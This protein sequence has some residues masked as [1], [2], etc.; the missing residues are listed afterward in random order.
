MPGRTPLIVANWKMN[1]TLS[2]AMILATS[3]RNGLEDIHGIEA[4]IC[5]PFPWLVPIAELFEKARL[6]HLTLG[7]QNMFWEDDGPFTGEVSAPMLKH[8]VSH[9]ILGHSERVS[10]FHETEEDTNR[11]VKA[12][13]HHHLKPIICVGET[14]KLKKILDGVGRDRLEE[15]SIAYE[16]VWAIG[17][18]EPASGAQAELVAEA[19]R[20]EFGNH[21]TFLYGGSVEPKNIL[22]FLSQPEID[23]ALIGGAS[24]SAHSFLKICELAVP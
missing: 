21:L 9:V 12:A 23:G 7:A 5:P 2:D 14:A 8:L 22:E 13:L 11:K 20:K 10:H 15:L 3:I 17:S 18:G 1:T 4:V 16:P 6:R 19:I 24:L